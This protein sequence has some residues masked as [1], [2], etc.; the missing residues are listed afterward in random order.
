[1]SSIAPLLWTRTGNDYVRDGLTGRL[2]SPKEFGDTIIAGAINTSANKKIG[3]DK[4]VFYAGSVNGGLY[5]RLYSEQTDTW[6]EQWTWESKPGSGYDGGQSIGAIAI[7]DDGKYLAVGRG[8]PSN[9]N[10]IGTAPYGI[11]LARIKRD[12]SLAWQETDISIRDQIQASPIRAL[13]WS[14]KS[15][16]ATTPGAVLELSVENGKITKVFAP[17]SKPFESSQ[18]TADRMPDNAVAVAGYFPVDQDQF[19]NAIVLQRDGQ[20]IPLI[21]EI[22]ANYI[23]S[24][25]ENGLF[26]SDI[27][28]YPKLIKGNGVFFV[29]S[30]TQDTKGN[31]WVSRIDRISIDLDSGKV[32]KIISSP[33]DRGLIGNNQASNLFYYGNFSLAADPFDPK[34]RAFFAGGN[35]FGSS[36]GSQ[37]L[38]YSGGLVRIRLK[39]DSQESRDAIESI[40]YLY[41][42]RLED[43]KDVLLPPAPGQPHADSRS[44]D[45]YYG[46]DGAKLIQTDDGGVWS[47][48][49]KLSAKG[50]KPKKRTWWMPLTPDHNGFQGLEV[51][52]VDWGSNANIIASSYQDNAASLGYFGDPSATNL[53]AGDGEIAIIDDGGDNKTSPTAYL[54]SQKYLASGGML[55]YLYNQKGFIKGMQPVSFGLRTE[56]GSILPWD[57]TPEFAYYVKDGVLIN[58]PPFLAPIEENPYAS[59]RIIMAGSVNAYETIDSDLNELNFRQLLKDNQASGIGFT[60][61]D[62]T[63]NL[64]TDDEIGSVYLAGINSNGQNIYGRQKKTIL[65]GEDPQAAAYLSPI[66]FTNITESQLSDYGVIIDISHRPSRTDQ[67]TLY[68]LQGGSSLLF[69]GSRPSPSQSVS[70]YLHIGSANRSVATFRLDQ[71]GLPVLA[72][73]VGYQSSVYIPANDH[74][75]E[76]LVIGGLAGVWISDLDEEGTPL[77]FEAM[78]WQGLDEGIAPGSYIRTIKYEPQDDLLILGTLGQGNW[79]YSFSGDLGDR[80]R[81]SKLLHMSNTS[82]VQG[83]E[84]DLDKRGNQFNR[85]ITIQLDGRLQSKTEATDV[86]IILHNKDKWRHYISMVSPYNISEDGDVFTESVREQADRWYSILRTF[87]LNYRGGWETKNNIVMPFSFDPGISMFNL[88]INAKDFYHSAPAKLR[89]SVRTT[90]GSDSVTRTLSLISEPGGIEEEGSAFLPVKGRGGSGPTKKRSDEIIHYTKAREQKPSFANIK[91]TPL[92]YT[93]P[94]IGQASANDVPSFVDPFQSNL[95]NPLEGD[96]SLLH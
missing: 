47:I 19:S 4:S 57:N 71:L 72:G 69:P 35:T 90:D 44:I 31:S 5:S 64:A 75:G 34:G 62:N 42:P 18:F 23:K 49:L 84:P 32:E 27:S 30:F 79:L 14:D 73:D 77:G 67:D 65:P 41:G 26:I 37:A 51:N 88:S 24:V 81:A 95:I 80:P 52:M 55:R 22:Y 43:N 45:F 6:S 50:A 61:L 7:S 92:T 2:G 60:A 58:E 91:S 39:G 40:S 17:V 29:G 10:H 25:N 78:N 38:T 1:M 13:E 33:I 82:L 53:W 59:N 16:I 46:Q 87:G 9:Y 36:P 8:N 20:T 83:T 89:Y 48:D 70:Q 86:E 15:L 85:A 94:F 3:N 74:H 56:D 68:I 66:V 54:S 21:G 12:G 76:K 93:D 28:A 63:S 96:L 11:Q